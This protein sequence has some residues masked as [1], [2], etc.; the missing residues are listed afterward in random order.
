MSTQTLKEAVAQRITNLGP[1]IE[2]SVVTVLTDQVKKKRS[3]AILTMLN[4]IEDAQKDLKKIKPDQQSFGA[5]NK[6]VSETFSK[7]AIDDKK[8]AEDKLTKMEAAL[9]LALDPVKPN[10]EKLFNIVNN[11]GNVPADTTE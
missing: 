2:E 8:K 10:Y 3:D 5:D 1:A 6:L 11:K 4:L 9:E 7:K